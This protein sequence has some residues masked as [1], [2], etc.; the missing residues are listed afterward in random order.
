MKLVINKPTSED[1]LQEQ[2]LDELILEYQLKQDK[3]LLEW[4]WN[5]VGHLGLDLLGIVP[6]IGIAADLANAIWYFNDDKLPQW[7][8][9]LFGGLSIVSAIPALG[10]ISAG[11]KL[12]GKGGGKAIRFTTKLATEAPKHTSLIKSA[13]TKAGK[14]PKI[15]EKN[16]KGAW[17]ALWSLL[18]GKKPKVPPTKPPGAVARQGAAAEKM[19]GKEFKQIA[20]ILNSLLNSN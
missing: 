17:E 3:L 18:R 7:E 8:R 6:G 10:W 9:W 1:L 19:I 13:L 11:I 20:S 14:N 15:G 12:L 5:D 4:D 16:A 2:K